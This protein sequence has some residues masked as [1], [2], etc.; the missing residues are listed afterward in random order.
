MNAEIISIGTE[1]TTGST[2]NT[3][4]RFIANRLL[5]LGIETYYHTSVDDNTN[6]LKN[7]IQTAFNRVNLIITTGGLGPTDDDLTKETISEALGIP[8]TKDS[9]MQD[10]IIKKFDSYSTMPN[11][12][13]KQAIKLEG[14]QFLNNYNGTAPGIFLSINDKILIMLPG[15]PREMKLMFN[16]EVIPL[17]H[18]DFNIIQKSINLLGI[19]ESLLEMEIKDLLNMDS[20]INLAT[21][22]K[23]GEVEIKI[24]GRGKDQTI[25]EKKIDN[26]V[27]II[28]SRFKTYIYGFDNI[29]IEKIVFDMLKEKK[30]KVGFCESCTGGLISGKLSRI[31]GASKVFD[32]SIITYSNQAKIEEVNVSPKT[33]EEFGP[34][35]E[36]VALEMAYGMLDHGNLDLAVSVTGLAGPSTE[37]DIHTPGL[38]YVCIATKNN[39][40]M[41]QLQLTGDRKHIQ[42]K[43]VTQVF[44]EMRKFLLD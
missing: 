5:E 42:N 28:E 21:F 1:I 6:R 3:N 26:M 17:I 15:P 29:P 41:I 38:V 4:S 34:V 2:L 14:S 30:Y 31:P 33:L 16:M 43:A 37:S 22:A 9:N 39:F 18:K 8:L 35:S 10:T 13:L 20:D 19:G 11:N 44:A 36:E 25:I 32:R 12:N 23:V 27:K 40:K 7:V 24:I